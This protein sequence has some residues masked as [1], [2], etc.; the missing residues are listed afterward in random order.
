MS[1]LLEFVKTL[2]AIL[3]SLAFVWM[4]WDVLSSYLHI[5]IDVGERSDN[6]QIVKTKVENRVK[7]SKE[8]DNALLLIGP[9]QE[10]PEET[11]NKLMELGKNGYRAES[12]NAI[13][14]KKL[15]KQIDDNEGRIVTPLPFYYDENVTIAD[16]VVNY[17]V[18]INTK[19]MQ[20][21]TPYSA[22]FFIWVKG[23]YHRS[24]QACFIK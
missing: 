5:D 7:K 9:E 16:E 24:T 14:E 21:G 13:A 23:R 1:G 10:E 17:C 3:G 2:G 4:I 18:P 20:E 11:Y 19:N 8:I 15:E 12:T 6:Y 22:R